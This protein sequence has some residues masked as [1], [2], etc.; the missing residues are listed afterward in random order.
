MITVQRENGDVIF[1]NEH[2]HTH[3]AFKKEERKF[4]AIPTQPTANIEIPRD[5]IEME[6]V[7]AVAYTNEAQPTSLIFQADKQ[8]APPTAYD[9]QPVM[10]LY[11]EINRLDELDK[12]EKEK[13]LR[14]RGSRRRIQ[15]SGRGIRFLNVC[16]QEEIETIG[17][18]VKMGRANFERVRNMG[19]DCADKVGEALENLYGIKW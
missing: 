4:I 15:K 17:Q 7:V 16:R 14:E 18:I 2:E 13:L 3:C 12:R 8:P 19:R 6:E 1:I 11:E 10:V 9:E 5:R